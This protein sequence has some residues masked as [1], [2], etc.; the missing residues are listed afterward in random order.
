MVVLGVDTTSS[1]SS[2][3]VV[4]DHAVVG[5]LRL[6]STANPSS[7]LVPA[8]EWLLAQLGLAREELDGFAVTT[9]PGSFTGL[10]VGLSTVQGMALAA[11]RPCCGLPALDVLAARI[12]GAAEQLVPMMDAF[13]GE[14][15]GAVYDGQARL[16]GQ[17]MVGPARA[18]LDQIGGAPAF[19][20]DAVDAHREQILDRLPEARFPSRSRYLAGTLAK[21]AVSRLE[22]G[23]GVE[24]S[25]LRPLYLRE[26][27]IG[28]PRR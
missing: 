24:P 3:A 6:A 25:Q 10:R 5:E 9:G 16:V 28:K 22:A 1:Q 21:I 14:V 8:V 4:R 2:V 13:R 26:A 23:E 27:H 11:A 17:R 19:I 20:G 18:L 15:F 7:T 12:A